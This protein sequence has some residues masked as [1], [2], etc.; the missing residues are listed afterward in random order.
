MLHFAA[1]D[2]PVRAGA[3]VW[4]LGGALLLGGCTVGPN[5]QRPSTDAPGGYFKESA[6]FKSA[7][8]ADDL[9]KGKWW[10]VY[11]DPQLNAL[12]E[13]VIVSNQTLKAAQAQFIQARAAITVNRAAYYPTVTAGASAHAGMSAN[14]KPKRSS[15]PPRPSPTPTISFRRSTSPGSP[16]SGAASAAPS[17]PP[18]PKRKPPPPTSPIPSSAC[19]PSSR[20]IISSSAASIPSSSFSIPPSPHIK[21]LST[22]PTV[23]TKAASPPTWTSRKTK[24]SLKPRAR[25]GRVDVQVDRTQFEHAIAVLIE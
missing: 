13:Q 5:Y 18:A 25:P 21:K 14:R 20:S 19:R 6:N 3:L 16:T 15:A 22:S 7:Q 4:L 10:E 23:A 1:P 9:S 11:N 24:P 17:K 2:A 8:P 12:E